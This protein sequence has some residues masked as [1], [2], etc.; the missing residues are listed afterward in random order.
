MRHLKSLKKT[1]R[2]TLSDLRCLL[3]GWSVK[4]PPLPG[5]PR[6]VEFICSGNI[7]RSIFAE[8]LARTMI[9]GLDL[10]HID[11]TSSGLHA[12]PGT[13]S[14]A[15]AIEAAEEYGIDLQSHA[16]MLYEPEASGSIDM[17]VC[18][19]QGQYAELKKISPHRSTHFFLLPLFREQNTKRIRPTLVYNI[20][21]PYGR[22]R[23]SFE[24]TFA[25]I[26]DCLRSLFLLLEQAEQEHSSAPSR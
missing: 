21:D 3:L 23:E 8:E 25:M 14:P 1:T 16:S 26:A 22:P 24:F 6:S 12:K 15:I 19:E 18:M 4:N 11:F 17:I 5:P 13:S 20:P 10:G 7:I 9:A 2:D